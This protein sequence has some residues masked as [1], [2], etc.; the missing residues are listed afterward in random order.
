MV[1]TKKVLFWFPLLQLQ[2]LFNF[3]LSDESF[4][5]HTLHDFAQSCL[6]QACPLHAQC[7][8]RQIPHLLSSVQAD[9]T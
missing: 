7:P 2:T 5:Q 6:Y 4:G 3:P 1:Y 8:F 9:E